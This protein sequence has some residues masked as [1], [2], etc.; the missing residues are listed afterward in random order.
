[1]GERPTRPEDVDLSK[2]EVSQSQYALI[3]PVTIMPR[4]TV[5]SVYLEAQKRALQAGIAYLSGL[6]PKRIVVRQLR[7]QDLGLPGPDWRLQVK[8]GMDVVLRSK[9]RDDQVIVIF[10][11]YNQSPSPKVMQLELIRD[12]VRRL[13]IVL[14]ELYT[15]G[16]DPMGVLA[17]FEVLRPGDEL[18][19]IAYSIGAGE[20]E[21]GIMGYVAEPEGR[22]R[23][24][25]A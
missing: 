10:G 24:E 21:L 2:Y 12:G 14:Q 7:P 18:Q 25:P 5:Y 3:F 15:K 19:L 6:Y 13:I 20:E 4:E 16:Y 11:F 17:D 8:V 1:M 23:R 22:V 9:V